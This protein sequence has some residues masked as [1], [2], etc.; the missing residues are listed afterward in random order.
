MKS[1]R[2][3]PLLAAVAL[4]VACSC[5]PGQTARTFVSDATFNAFAET[6]VTNLGYLTK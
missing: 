1:N 4:A 5:A 2:I 6:Y 3:L